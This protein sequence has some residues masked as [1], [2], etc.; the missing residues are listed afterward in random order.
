M[1][2]SIQ[3]EFSRRLGA[4]TSNPAHLPLGAGGF[5]RR[6]LVPPGKGRWE[7]RRKLPEASQQWESDQP[8]EPRAAAND[9]AALRWLERGLWI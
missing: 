9:G 6:D 2:D 3:A 7:P 5:H 4:K 8:F 1:H